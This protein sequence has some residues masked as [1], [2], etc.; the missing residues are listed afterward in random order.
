[1]VT[2]PYEA[3]LWQRS[4]ASPSI[5]AR[6]MYQKYALALPFYRQE[7]LF[8]DLGVCLSRQTMCNWVLQFSSV[9]F[10]PIYDYLYKKLME[11]PYHQC[12]ETTLQVNRDGRSAGTKSFLWLHSTSELSGADPIIMFCFELT[13]GT[14]HLR[15]FYEDFRGY[16]SCDAYCSYQVLAKE[17]VD[18]ILV[19]GCMMHMRRRFVESLSL[20]DKSK[21]DDDAVS[22]L[23]EAKALALIGEIYNADEPLKSLSAE[24]RRIRREEEVRPLVQDYFQYIE[25]LDTDDPL[26]AERLKDAVNYSKNQKEYLCRFLEDGHIPCDNGFAERNIRAVALFRNNSLFCDSIGGAKATA[27]MY[28]IVE[29]ARANKANAYWYLRYVLEKMPHD[30]A[31]LEDSFLESMMPWSADYREYEKMCTSQ[32]P[33]ELRE[34]EYRE[35]PKTPRKVKKRY[36]MAS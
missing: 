15:K 7:A 23:P 27:I 26:M 21:L 18:A 4:F 32:G 5:T 28:S 3:P 10:G 19:C 14:D 9:Y 12:D 13:R 25:S 30:A 29:T 1:M 36:D 24:D 11:V 35:R 2:V 17:K 34:N 31:R 8:A 22:Q 33:P 20:I 6:V 16:I